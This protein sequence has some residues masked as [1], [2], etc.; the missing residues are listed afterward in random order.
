[1]MLFVLGDDA[2]DEEAEAMLQP[3]HYDT[4]IRVP[5]DETMESLAARAGAFSS[6]SD[7]R[8]NGFLGAVPW[9]LDLYGAGSTFFFAWSPHHP[10]AAV[11]IGKKKRLWKRWEA[12]LNEMGWNNM[13]NHREGPD[14][15]C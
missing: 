9:G 1:M 7:A 3:E 5:A 11:K 10:E 8:R 2:T 15:E 14:A 13:M 4:I 6:K 12:F